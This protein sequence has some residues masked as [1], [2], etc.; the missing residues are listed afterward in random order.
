MNHNS[1]A[2]AHLIFV[3]EMG[4][5]DGGPVIAT[6]NAF[7]N[8]QHSFGLISRDRINRVWLRRRYSETDAAHQRRIQQAFRQVLPCLTAV[9]SAPDAILCSIFLNC[10]E[11]Q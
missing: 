1:V 10:R 4:S 5:S 8:T 3:F 7:E 2:V 11:D 9:F 6:I